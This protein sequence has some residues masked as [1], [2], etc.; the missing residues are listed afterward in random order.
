MSNALPGAPPV[1]ARAVAAR[2]KARSAAATAF[3]KRKRVILNL[4]RA[5][6]SGRLEHAV[7]LGA[8]GAA[9]LAARLI[10]ESPDGLTLT[11]A[12]RAMLK[13]MS[14]KHAASAQAPAPLGSGALPVL[15]PA[16]GRAQ[17]DGEKAITTMASS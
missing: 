6:R 9:L 17:R 8:W 16:R 11:P 14:K 10:A 5:V 15:L 3:R 12:G 7:Q 13:E 2:Q 1:A 4:L